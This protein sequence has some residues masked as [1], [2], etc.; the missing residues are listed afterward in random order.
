MAFIAPL[1]SVS[2]AAFDDTGTGTGTSM[3]EAVSVHEGLVL[4][5][6]SSIYDGLKTGMVNNVLATAKEPCFGTMI[7]DEGAVSGGGACNMA[8]PSSSAGPR[9]ASTMRAGISARVRLSAVPAN[10]RTPL[11]TMI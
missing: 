6:V 7:I 2:A 5:K 10:G 1:L 3:N 9:P 11:V 8:K 4:I